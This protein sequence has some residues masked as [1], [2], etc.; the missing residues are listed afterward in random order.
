MYTYIQIGISY[1]YLYT[2][3]QIGISCTYMYIY[4]QTLTHA[5][6]PK[7]KKGMSVLELLQYLA[8][9]HSGEAENNVASPKGLRKAIPS[10]TD[11][12]YWYCFFVC[13]QGF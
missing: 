3:I 4:K 6:T 7:K 2:Y 1:I 8:L 12:L 11:K 9:Y 5:Y 13:D 10:I